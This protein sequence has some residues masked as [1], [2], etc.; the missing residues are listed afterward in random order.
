MI[1][2]AEADALE[3]TTKDGDV[4]IYRENRG[5][6]TVIWRD[7]AEAERRD[8]EAGEHWFDDIEVDPMCLCVHLRAAIE[9]REAGRR[10]LPV[11]TS[12]EDLQSPNWLPLRAVVSDPDPW[13]WMDA[14]VHDG[15]RID[16]YKHSK[17][18]SY[19]SLDSAGQAYRITATGGSA[20]WDEGEPEPQVVTVEQIDM[21]EALREA[22]A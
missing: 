8:V 19:L 11:G 10:L 2:I 18:R 1:T 17:T 22:L 5:S 13:M 12:D 3:A 16:H 21:A 4:L 6:W 20:P 7:D 9:V 14:T 15:K